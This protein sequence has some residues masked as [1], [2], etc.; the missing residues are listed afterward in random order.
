[1][2]ARKNEDTNAKEQQMNSKKGRPDP[3]EQ[4]NVAPGDDDVTLTVGRPPKNIQ[5]T[6]A[7]QASK[8]ASGRLWNNYKNHLVTSF[9]RMSRADQEAL[10]QRVCVIVTIGV[11]GIALLLFYQ[12]IPRLG[13]VFGVPLSVVGA[14]WA[15]KNVVT[16]VVLARLEDIMNKE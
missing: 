3:R 9:R 15:G 11:T 7:W 14:F 12:F 6:Q 8:Q 16:P 13:R 2:A 10:V 5:Q 1:V 4:I